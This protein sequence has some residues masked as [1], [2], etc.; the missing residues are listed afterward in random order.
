MKK[1]VNVQESTQKQLATVIVFDSIKERFAG[2]RG[3]SGARHVVARAGEL[4]I[5]LKIST[6]PS[7][8]G[9]TGQVF[10]RND[11]QFMNTVRVQ[12]L[13]DGTPF[14]T[15]WSDN[16]GQFEFEEV[17][18]GAFSLHIDLPQLTIVSGISIG[19]RP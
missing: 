11:T 5:H 4:D 8:Q 17:P 1:S 16:F 3:P 19:K 7:Q 2:A 6:N 12:L 10:A 18:S 9:I 15:T 13:Q 14:K